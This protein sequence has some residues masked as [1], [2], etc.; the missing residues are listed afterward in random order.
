MTISD[1]R[2]LKDDLTRGQA[3]S[4]LVKQGLSAKKLYSKPDDAIAFIYDATKRRNKI[5]PITF[6]DDGSKFIKVDKRKLIKHDRYGYY[7]VYNG[8]IHYFDHNKNYEE[9]KFI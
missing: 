1:D 2:Y 7:L 8:L 6:S 5:S 9:S 3:V 4:F